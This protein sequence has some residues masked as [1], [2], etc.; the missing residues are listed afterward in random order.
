M[1]RYTLPDF[2]TA[3]AAP[4]P[5]ESAAEPLAAPIS[6]SPEEPAA[7]T[8][9][10]ALH[11]MAVSPEEGSFAVPQ[12]SVIKQLQKMVSL[13]YRKIIAY[14]NYG[15]RLR[16]HFRDSVAEHFDEHVEHER[17]HVRD[18][19]IKLTALGGE[20]PV[21]VPSFLDTPDLHQ[22]IL[23]VLQYEKELVKEC[24]AL[25]DMAGDNIA[26]KAFAEDIAVRDQRH[27]DDMR[28]ILFCE[29]AP[30]PVVKDSPEY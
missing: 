19:T 25:A 27:A 22:I 11:P 9:S 5:D 23:S 2:V 20:P 10:V 28:R 3:S 24:R 14:I 15:D 1:S 18:L 13:K 8:A 12:E 7:P 26:L 17:D 29:G 6:D 21:K 30:G 4:S 16:A